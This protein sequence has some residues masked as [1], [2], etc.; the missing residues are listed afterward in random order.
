MILGTFTAIYC[1]IAVRIR[2]G[3]YEQVDAS[4]FH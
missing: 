2:K 4:E 3:Q 1:G